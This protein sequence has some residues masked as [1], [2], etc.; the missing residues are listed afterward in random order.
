MHLQLR[1]IR[2][3]GPFQCAGS[4]LCPGTVMPQMFQI[5]MQALQGLRHLPGVPPSCTLN[6]PSSWQQHPHHVS[7][8]SYQPHHLCLSLAFVRSICLLH[9]GH[10]CLSAASAP[11]VW[12]RLV[13]ARPHVLGQSLQCHLGRVCD[14]S[15]REAGH[16]VPAS[17]PRRDPACAMQDESMVKPASHAAGGEGGPPAPLS[18]STASKP[19]GSPSR[20]L[21]KCSFHHGRPGGAT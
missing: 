18:T 14:A 6:G 5:P 21:C 17:E 2:A 7:S 10:R 1:S 13:G 9:R 19:L 11:C 16:T 15:G 4:H 8:S 12:G 20:L 3:K